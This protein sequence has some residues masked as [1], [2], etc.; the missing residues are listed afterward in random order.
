MER[1][2]PVQLRNVD[3]NLLVPLKALLHERNVT[4]AAERI[5]LSQSAMSRTLDRL[6][7][8]LGDELLVRVGRNYELSPR[9]SA[10]LGELGQILPRV[11]RLWAG[12]PFSPAQS[13]ANIRLAMTDDASSVVLPPLAE[14]VGRLAPGITLEVVPWHERTHEDNLTTH[15][16]VSPLVVPSTF[17]FEPLFE[18]TFVC[19][20]GRKLKRRRGAITMK[21]YL[22][23]RHIA[24]ETQAKQQNLIDRSLAEAGLRRLVAVHLP[25]FQAAIRVLETTD[26][27]L[28]M[29]ARIA[30]PTLAALDFPLLEAPKEVPC[31]RY[32][33]V[34]HPR[35]DTD[36]LHR[37]IRDTVRQIFLAPAR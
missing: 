10:L 36:Q 16:I 1:M 8:E 6:R 22:S 17:R 27:V 23:F 25:Y 18:D 9:G 34:W 31:I 26:L 21:E 33:M 5:N 11:A 15:L 30:E 3:L 4:R 14:I 35:F 29:P 12:E 19:V 28:T 20:A 32:S 2:R 7:S 37:W 24:I 13:E